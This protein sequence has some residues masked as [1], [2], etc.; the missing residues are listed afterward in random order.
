MQAASSISIAVF[1][2]EAVLMDATLQLSLP[3][4]WIGS[5]LQLTT[6]WTFLVKHDYAILVRCLPVEMHLRSLP[7]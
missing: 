3:P 1:A 4:T 2:E 7:V 6:M 5:H